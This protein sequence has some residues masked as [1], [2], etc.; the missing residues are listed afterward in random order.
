MCARHG[1]QRRYYDP[2]ASADAERM[3]LPPSKMLAVRPLHIQPLPPCRGDPIRAG[4]QVQGSDGAQGSRCV[5]RLEP[6]DGGRWLFTGR[7]TLCVRL[8]FVFV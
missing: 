8:P 7:I 6:V 4:L 3:D 5:I 1:N 2:F